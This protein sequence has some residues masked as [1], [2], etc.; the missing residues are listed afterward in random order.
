MKITI[1]GSLEH[2]SKP[3]TKGLVQEG[4]SVKVWL[5]AKPREKRTSRPSEP[6]PPSVQ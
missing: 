5:A 1:T 6:Q 3:L 2:I 4:H